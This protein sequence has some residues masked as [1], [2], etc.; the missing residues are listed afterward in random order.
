MLWILRR[1]NSIFFY[2]NYYCRVLS[3]LPTKYFVYGR[4]GRQSTVKD[5]ELS[6][7]PLWDVVTPSAWMDHSCQKLNIHNIGELSWFL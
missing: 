7:Q 4:I 6:F 3:I 5:G 1:T 2:F